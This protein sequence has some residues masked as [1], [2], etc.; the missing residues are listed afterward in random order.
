MIYQFHHVHLLCS[1]LQNSIDFFT[2]NLGAA[3]VE[4]KKFGAADGATLD[5]NGTMINFRVAADNEKVTADTSTPAYGYHHIAVKVE[6]I[7]AAHKELSDK[8]VACIKSPVDAGN[9]RI[10]FFKGPDDIVFEVLQ[11]I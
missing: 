3:V 8:G 11:P 10:A 2:E 5:L 4:Y 7:D 9:N 1:D 6:D